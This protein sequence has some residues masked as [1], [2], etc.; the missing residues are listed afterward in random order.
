MR[1]EKL[2]FAYP[3]PFYIFHFSVL[4]HITS[5]Q[6]K[7]EIQWWESTKQEQMFEQSDKCWKNRNVD[8]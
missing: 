4:H 6:K 3:M 5:W 8:I 1:E 7:N 2:L